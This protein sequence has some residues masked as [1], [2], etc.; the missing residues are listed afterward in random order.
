MYL[1]WFD[2]V[3]LGG[4]PLKHHGDRLALIA[5]TVRTY[6]LMRCICIGMCK[7]HTCVHTQR[8]SDVLHI[9]AR[10]LSHQQPSFF[11]AL[12]LSVV[13]VLVCEQRHPNSLSFANVRKVVHLRDDKGLSWCDIVKKVQNLKGNRPSRWLVTDAYTRFKQKR[14]RTIYSYKNC[15]RKPKLTKALQAWLV[16]R[17]LA[18][19]KTSFCSSCVLQR[20]LAKK[21]HVIVEASTIRR[22]L[23]KHGFR[24]L[25]RP[26]KL[27]YTPAQK[28]DRLAFSKAILAMTDAELKLSLAFSSDGVVLSVPPVSTTD[29]ENYCH[30]G[31]THI[32]CTKREHATLELP[33]PGKYPKQVPLSRAV[34]MWGGCSYE[35]FAIVLFHPNKKLTKEEWVAALRAGKLTKAIR[36][37]N[38][39]RRS[40]PW[41]MLCDNEKF[42]HAKAVM[43]E[44]GRCNIK[45]WKMPAKSPD[46][47]PIEKFWSWLRQRLVA[48]D[49]ADLNAGRPP[50]G[51]TAYKIRVRNICKTQR[52]QRVAGNCARNLRKVA[53]AV[54]K[55]KG[56]SAA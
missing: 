3:L 12:A 39:S 24:W 49:L 26:N 11:F 27:K 43:P 54:V 6:T 5:V 42:L 36:S 25:V 9:I 44:Y 53:K 56:A 7:A 20:E 40:G 13:M 46:L 10:S 15:G 55:Q 28:A 17:L 47:N 51:K 41:S 29:R 23:K 37:V 52:A 1:F 38:R 2:L 14:A 16:R 35:G 21:Q 31:Q 18:L 34:P 30:G 48:K 4:A 32:W 50:L 8:A 22:V 19:R 33:A 45:L